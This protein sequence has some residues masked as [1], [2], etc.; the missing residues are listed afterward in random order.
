MELSI[1]YELYMKPHEVD[2]DTAMKITRQAGFKYVD[3]STGPFCLHEKSPILKPNAVKWAEETV[4]TADKYGIKMHQAH[5]LLFNYLNKNAPDYQYLTDVNMKLLDLCKP[6]G[7]EYFIFHPGTSDSTVSR[8]KSV[9][10]TKQW[11]LPFVERAHKLGVKLCIENIFDCI[12]TDRTILRAVGARPDE[13]L[14][15]VESL[16]S[17]NVG[18]CWDCGHAHIAKLDQKESLHLLGERVWTTHI[19]DNRGQYDNDLHIPPFYGSIDW[20]SLMEGLCEINYKGTFNFEIERH[21]IPLDF[22]YDEFV[23]IYK[24]GER[25]LSMMK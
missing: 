8:K 1:A 20:Q 11:L 12:G 25:L 5:C 17:E 18:I 7:I 24:K 13:L 23:S 10:A 2:T 21:T 15:V 16:D 14:E 19:H 22:V 9:D 3:M 4:Q 6:L